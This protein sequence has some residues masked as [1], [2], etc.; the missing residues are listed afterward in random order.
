M[1]ARR[2]IET[3]ATIP[4]GLTQPAVFDAGG[5]RCIA[6]AGIVAAPG[7][8]VVVRRAGAVV[9]SAARHRAMPTRCAVQAGAAI[10]ASLAESPILD[11][12]VGCWAM[13]ARGAIE[14]RTTVKTRLA[15]PAV[16]DAGVVRGIARARVAVTAP[17]AAFIVRRAGA[18]IGGALLSSGWLDTPGES[19]GH[20][21]S[22]GRAGD[23]PFEYI[24][25]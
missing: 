19:S 23:Q 12:G 6:I 21:C 16:F 8:A 15:E 3:Q 10:E 11:T 13:P 17:R 2:A 14:T 7:A 20:G 5:I 4:A 18:V 24:A 25:S 1:T 9:S 22:A